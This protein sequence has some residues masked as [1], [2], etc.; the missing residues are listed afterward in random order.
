MFNLDVYSYTRLITHSANL[1]EIYLNAS[2]DQLMVLACVYNTI[3]TYSIS[4]I[5]SNVSQVDRVWTILPLLY[6]VIPAFD[7]AFKTYL[8]APPSIPLTSI[9]YSTVNQRA[10]LLLTLQLIWSARLTFNTARRGLMAF[11]SEDYRWPIV[12]GKLNWWQFKLLNLFFVAI[13]QNILHLITGIPALIIAKTPQYDVNRNDYLIFGLGVANITAEFIADNQQYA[14]Q[15]WK[16][17]S[18]TKIASEKD[19]LTPKEKKLY[20]DGFNSSGLFAISRH[21][22]FAFEQLNWWIWS[23]LVVLGTKL[24]GVDLLSVFISPLSMSLLFE[25]STRLTESISLSKYPS[26]NEYR[27]HVAMFI[28]QFTLLK[29]IFNKLM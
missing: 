2:T 7:L 10:L 28:P 19:L 5:T 15:S 13:A 3:W 23:L 21:P 17:A 8:Q 9:L 14:Y 6:T 24:D 22:N 20:A 12:R 1:K 11:A 26:Y 4:E 29:K 16:R 25:A 18:S 27:N